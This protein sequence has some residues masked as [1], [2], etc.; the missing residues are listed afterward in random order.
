MAYN[1][2]A[3][4]FFKKR[5]TCLFTVQNCI[6]RLIFLGSAQSSSTRSP[7]CIH[8]CLSLSALKSAESGS[9]RYD[10][11]SAV[12]KVFLTVILFSSISRMVLSAAGHVC[13]V[14][15]SSIFIMKLPASLVTGGGGLTLTKQ[16]RSTPGWFCKRQVKI[17][18]HNDHDDDYKVNSNCIFSL[19]FKW[20]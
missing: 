12:L 9:S 11:W 17:Y 15:R 19:S 7:P 3:Y 5:N 20:V 1:T 10:G 8:L 6:K 18:F 4:Q 13:C 2:H 14:G 16:V